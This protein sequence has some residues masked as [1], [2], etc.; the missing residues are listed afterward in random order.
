MKRLIISILFLVIA[1]EL[2]VLGYLHRR[3]YPKHF[4]VVTVSLVE[5]NEQ[6][7]ARWTVEVARR[8]PDAVVVIGHGMVV[9]EGE[10]LLVDQVHHKYRHVEEV[11]A[12]YQ[13]LYP[14]RPL[15][16]VCCNSTHIHLHI[17]GVWYSLQDVDVVP[18]KNIPEASAEA[19]GPPPV[20]YNVD[21]CGNI[22]EFVED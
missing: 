9:V 2:C 14:D 18:D 4:G 11:V 16:L 22:F 10:W 17:K 12:S 13:H 3:P 5:G 21:S 1:A 7:V 8:F 19:G 15:V 6:A 20:G